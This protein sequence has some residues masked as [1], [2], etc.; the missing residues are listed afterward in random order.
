[1][2]WALADEVSSEEWHPG[3]QMA[4]FLLCL[5]VAEKGRDFSDVSYK[6]IDPIHQ[7]SA[8]MV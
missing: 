7:D 2:I 3:S 6:T 4:F 1:M 5:Y 8:L